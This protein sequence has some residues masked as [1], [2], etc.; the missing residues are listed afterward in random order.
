LAEINVTKD[1]RKSFK[2][3][4][5]TSTKFAAYATKNVEV[6]EFRGVPDN[7]RFVWLLGYLP[8]V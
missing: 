2:Q 3:S 5:S 4:P 1:Q 8:Q 7:S 6:L